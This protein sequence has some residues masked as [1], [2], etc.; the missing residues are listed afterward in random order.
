MYTCDPESLLAVV[1]TVHI[2]CMAQAVGTVVLKSTGMEASCWLKSG[3]RVNSYH[4]WTP[5]VRTLRNRTSTENWSKVSK[6][7]GMCDQ[8]CVV[9]VPKIS[10]QES[11]KAVINLSLRSE[12]LKRCVNRTRV[13]S[14]VQ[15]SQARSVSR[16]SKKLSFRSKFSERTCEQNTGLSSA[17]GLKP[18]ECRG[19][20]K[21]VLRVHIS[22]RMCEQIWVSEVH[23][24]LKP[25]KCPRQSTFCVFS[26]ANLLR[27]CG[28]Q[29]TGIVKCPKVSSQDKCR[30]SQQL[31]WRCE[32]LR[33]CVN[34]SRYQKH[35]ARSRAG[36]MNWKQSYFVSLKKSKTRATKHDDQIKEHSS[37]NRANLDH[38][39]VDAWWLIPA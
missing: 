39:E 1:K 24:N 30:G 29:N 32:F 2:C 19:S 16:Q 25:G 28:E 21:I 18:G 15:G 17:Q 31:S 36:K 22:K 27:G 20:Q 13:M 5:S 38:C 8:I 6:F 37:V 33:G 7:S 3:V 23:Q 26:G 9:E 11:V 34:R 14:S 4:I 10:T 12:F 35:Y